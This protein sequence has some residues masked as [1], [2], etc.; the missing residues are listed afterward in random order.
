MDC[1]RKAM[2]EPTE[3]LYA[4][5]DI[6]KLGEHYLRH[7]DHMTTEALYDKGDIAAELAWRDLRIAQLTAGIQR[8]ARDYNAAMYRQDKIMRMLRGDDP[9]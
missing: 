9:T 7:V 2:S 4:R 6:E 3:K 5:R 8:L 1:E